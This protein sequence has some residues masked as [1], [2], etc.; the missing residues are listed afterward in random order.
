MVSGLTFTK[1]YEPVLYCFELHNHLKII[2]WLNG[3]H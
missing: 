2:T 1:I 3:I